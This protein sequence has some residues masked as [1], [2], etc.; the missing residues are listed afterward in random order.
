MAD[1]ALNLDPAVI[2]TPDYGDLLFKNGGVRLTSDTDGT[3]P[4]LQRI[5]QRLRLLTGEWFLNTQEGVPWLQQILV[6]NAS[7]ATVDALLQD[8]IL[9]TPG[10]LVLKQY[11]STAFR[12]QRR[13]QVKFTVSTVQGNVVQSTVN[14]TP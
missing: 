8:T 6:K 9:G 13:Y 1:F 3:N 12:A 11:Q 5:V 4:T 2:G 14:I 7:Q 10:V